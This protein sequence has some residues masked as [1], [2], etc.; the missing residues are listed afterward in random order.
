MLDDGLLNQ[1]IQSFYGYG[2]F[3]AGTWFIGMEESGGESQDEVRRR[4]SA[5]QS[6]GAQ[7]LEDARAYHQALGMDQFFRE[8]VQLQPTWAQLCRV[9]LAAQGAPGD[10]EAIKAYQKEKLGRQDGE[11][12]LLALLPLPTPGT[13][14]WF[15]PHWSELN[16]LASRSRYMEEV[17]PVRTQELKRRLAQW[18]PR[19]VVFYGLMYREYW[20][21]IAGVDFLR[22][23]PQGFYLA[24]KEGA[25]YLVVQHPAAQGVSSRYFREAGRV[26][27]L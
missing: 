26:L 2:S 11:T 16:F 14:R 15:Y 3:A 1:F 24:R 10:L 4:L 25:S 6:R 12:C 20:Q 9:A 22:I 5:W 18:Q 21:A 17:L 23:D 19:S 8:P 27:G 13:D 7:E